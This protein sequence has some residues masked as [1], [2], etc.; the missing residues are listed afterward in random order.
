MTLVNLSACIF[1]I[2]ACMLFK[3]VKLNIDRVVMM[4]LVSS[5]GV[6]TKLSLVTAIFIGVFRLVQFGI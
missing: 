2:V 5:L 4:Q 3:I 1:N 6:H